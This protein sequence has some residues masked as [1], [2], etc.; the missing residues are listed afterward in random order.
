MSSIISGSRV[1]RVIVDPK[2]EWVSLKLTTDNGSAGMG[3]AMCPSP[4]ALLQSALEIAAANLEGTSLKSAAPPPKSLADDK[5]TGLLEATVHATIDQCLWD[6][7][8]RA[9][10]IPVYAA[11]GPTLRTAIPL[12]ANINRGTRDR[13]PENFAR[14]A[15]DAIADG[16][17]AVKIAPFDGL[18][19]QNGH[20]V[21]GR[22]ALAL[23]LERVNAVRDA[24]GLDNLL[25]IDCHCRFHLPGALQF[26]KAA[27]PVRIDWFEDVLPYHELT[28][29]A[30]LRANSSVLL[31]GGETARG[32]RDLL[33]FLDRGIW[34]VVMPD[35]RFIGITEL[36]ALGPLAEQYQVQL[37]P[38]NP[39]GPIG[40]AASAHAVVGA[41]AFRVLE[42]QHGEIEWRGALTNGT[43]VI[44]NGA[45]ELS[46]A[47]GL[48]ID[49]DESTVKTHSVS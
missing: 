7:R 18:T 38:H 3:E 43:E 16:F 42:F 9:A 39:R 25:M 33:P 41:R 2:T 23:G 14:R 31:A 6:L 17:D 44:R 28:Q 35:V 47:P 32:I 46:D 40:T 36:A 8:T 1:D 30:H 10:G 26:L 19:R 22:N 29:W 13:S 4:S 15:A 5:A 34:D 45:L 49:W 12:Y 27:E 24:I 48:G 37:A 11:L 20:T 21:A